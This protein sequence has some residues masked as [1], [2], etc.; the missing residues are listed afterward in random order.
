MPETVYKRKFVP[1]IQR[2][3]SGTKQEKDQISEK[4]ESKASPGSAEEESRETSPPMM[5]YVESLRVFSGRYNTGERPWL[6][7]WRPFALLASPTVLV[8][9]NVFPSCQGSKS[10]S[11]YIQ[12]AVIV[13]GTATSC[14]KF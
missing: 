14:K 13:Y 8:C 6:F 1:Q 9:M 7:I 11:L 2:T 12:W 5:S 10:T 4:G 3:E